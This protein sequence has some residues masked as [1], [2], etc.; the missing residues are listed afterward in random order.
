MKTLYLNDDLVFD[1]DESSYTTR[2]VA[3]LSMKKWK[4]FDRL[5]SYNRVCQ[6]LKLDSVMN[7][8]NKSGC[9]KK[10]KKKTIRFRSVQDLKLTL[11]NLRDLDSTSLFL[12]RKTHTVSLQTSSTLDLPLPPSLVPLP[13]SR[14]QSRL[15]GFVSWI[16][17][18]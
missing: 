8:I 11:T 14:S 12:S 18:Y 17:S 10:K 4:G 9:L 15:Q 1:D 7:M 13:R 3:T 6:R 16:W 2:A 5:T